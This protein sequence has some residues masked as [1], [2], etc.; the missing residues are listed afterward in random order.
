[1][2]T[3]T[4]SGSQDRQFLDKNFEKFLI[5]CD[6]KKV[7]SKNCF[8]TDCHGRFYEH[9]VHLSVCLDLFFFVLS[10]KHRPKSS[11]RNSTKFLQIHKSVYEKDLGR[12]EL[13]CHSNALDAL[14]RQY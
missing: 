1:M 9:E 2:N 5:I 14:D 6:L 11:P 4:S 7:I 13:Q 8:S 12:I 3:K 10:S